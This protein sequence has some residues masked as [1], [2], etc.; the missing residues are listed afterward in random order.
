MTEPT[1]AFGP[2]GSTGKPVHKPAIINALQGLPALKGL[3]HAA[4]PCSIVSP[5]PVAGTPC[6]KRTC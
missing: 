3:Q 6:F 2:A 4:L 1:A 5:T